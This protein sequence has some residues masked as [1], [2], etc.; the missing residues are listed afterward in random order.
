MTFFSLVILVASL[1]YGRLLMLLLAIPGGL[2]GIMHLWYEGWSLTFRGGTII[3][4]IWFREVGTYS[5]TD[6]TDAVR[7]YSATD[8]EYLSLYFS[9]GRR[10]V[11]R[12]KDEN[13][14]EAIKLV[15]KRHSVRI[16]N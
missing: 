7:G 8:R 13:G 12:Q 1:W 2:F 11:L 6:L 4:R 9:D 5:L 14:A 10:L 3:R 16:L 15:R